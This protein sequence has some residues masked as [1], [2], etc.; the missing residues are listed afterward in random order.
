VVFLM[1]RNGTACVEAIVLDRTSRS[2]ALRSCLLRADLGDRGVEPSAAAR[3][4]TAS[5]T[6]R[7]SFFIVCL[8]NM[9]GTSTTCACDA[10]VKNGQEM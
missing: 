8:S 5:K 4:A 10:G 3:R 6:L 2:M 9:F 1:R 7:S